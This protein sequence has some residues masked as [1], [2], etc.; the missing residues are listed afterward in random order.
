MNESVLVVACMH[1]F[2]MII[3]EFCVDSGQLGD[4]DSSLFFIAYKY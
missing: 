1:A 4:S 3:E 2:D